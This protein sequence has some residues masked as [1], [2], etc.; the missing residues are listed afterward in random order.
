M[1]AAI[2]KRKIQLL[3]KNSFPAHSFFDHLLR[4]TEYYHSRDFELAAEEWGAAEWL[5]YDTPINLKRPGG[6]I[7]CGGFIRDVP[8]L[9]FLY[10]VFASKANG[11][12][13]IKTDGVSKNLVFNEGRLVRAATTSR[14]ERIGNFIAK[15]ESLSP[16]T[17]DMLVNDAKRQHKKIGEYLVEKGVLSKDG[18][19][20]LLLLQSEQILVD[21]L[22]WQNGY[23]YFFERPIARDFIVNYDPFHLVRAATC[24]DFSLSRFRSRLS[25]MKII[26]RPSPYA[27]LKREEILQKL[28]DEYKFIYSLVDGTRNIEQIARFSGIDESSAVEKLYR[29]NA[30]GMIRQSLEIIEYEDRQYKEIS[31][32]LDTLL[33]I[34][35]YM[36]Q[37]LFNEIGTQAVHIIRKS[38]AGIADTYDG[39]FGDIPWEKPELVNRNLILH[40]VARFSPDPNQR[41]R[42]IEAFRD[43]FLLL[44]QETERY[45]GGDFA[46]K[47]ADKINSEIKNVIRYA[48]E[49]PLRSHLIE[50]FDKL[51]NL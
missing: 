39:F 46:D 45:L 18:L 27:D 10:A 17:L 37:K 24:K 8:F 21:I 13:A 29:L 43:L 51:M 6:R 36:T 15:K 25:S 34:Y 32:L 33:E 48:R 47:A 11:I 1:A 7:F 14:K 42:F 49:T 22:K 2:V 26:F 5:N 3:K 38:T 41:G 31:N 30:A 35:A 9:F 20:Q 12:G 40:S 28:S 4:G 19:R 23:F 50:T 44:R 16:T